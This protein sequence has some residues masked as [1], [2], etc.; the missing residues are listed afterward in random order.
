MRL[1]HAQTLVPR[2]RETQL[3]RADSPLKFASAAV[4]NPN[5]VVPIGVDRDFFLHKVEAWEKVL[6]SPD[7]VPFLH[8]VVM[9]R[10]KL[11]K[12]V[13]GVLDGEVH[14]EPARILDFSF[15]AD[16]LLEKRLLDH[17]IAA[18]QADLRSV[19]QLGGSVIGEKELFQLRID[20]Q[21]LFQDLVVSGI[22][23][24][25]LAHLEAAQG[26]LLEIDKF[27]ETLGRRV[28]AI[29]SLDFC[30]ATLH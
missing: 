16:E 12:N 22:N 9:G 25:F 15:R 27:L 23:D 18:T 24:G 29:T 30:S 28:K 11:E 1:E 21:N 2:Q 7:T 4:I 17:I 19:P 26:D 20:K 10:E 5:M 14:L 3:F 8:T 6:R 13:K